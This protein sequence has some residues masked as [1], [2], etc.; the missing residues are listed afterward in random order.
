MWEHDYIKNHYKLIAV[1]LSRPKELDSDPKALQKI[2]FVGQ[3]KNPINEIDAN[4]SMFVLTISEKIKETR[5]EFSQ[6]S[7]TVL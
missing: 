1:Y 7:V 6:R 2:E 4:E 3:L 5:L